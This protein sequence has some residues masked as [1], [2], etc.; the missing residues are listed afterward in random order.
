MKRPASWAE[1]IAQR[2]GA[3]VLVR[4]Q[5]GVLQR[6]GAETIA[7]VAFRPSD[8]LGETQQSLPKKLVSA[9]EF[10]RL[11]ADVLAAERA[12]ISLAQEPE[13]VAKALV[14]RIR[15]LGANEPDVQELGDVLSDT[16]YE[17]PSLLDITAAGALSAE[18]QEALGV[19]RTRFE[20]KLACVE[21]LVTPC[22]VKVGCQD[23]I[24]EWMGSGFVFSG[25]D[26][27]LVM[28]AKHVIERAKSIYLESQDGSQGRATV[29]AE[30]DSYDLAI[31]RPDE[32][33][34][35]PCTSCKVRLKTPNQLRGHQVLLI[36][37]HAAASAPTVY[38]Q[39][40]CASLARVVPFAPLRRVQFRDG[41]AQTCLIMVVEPG[42]ETVREGMS[43]G[44]I[45]DLEAGQA[46]IVAVIT[47]AQAE[48]I[49]QPYPASGSPERLPVAEYAFGTLI[50][51]SVKS[52]H[53][54]H[55]YF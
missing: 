25:S 12:S 6:Y 10:F 13:Q 36:G 54:L 42:Q 27:P 44:P 53:E 26:R 37:F 46:E 20:E 21:E 23:G 9:A 35:I 1:A 11:L 48:L 45:I 49:N 38:I 22:L 14:E 19:F 51:E 5:P 52:S 55:G 17:K 18:S 30:A 16:F 40:A 8:L 41:W 7:E 31:L 39:D 47:G 29:V 4:T 33:K 15:T 50:Q 32:L 2:L 34:E 3:E 28:T 24:K 43:G